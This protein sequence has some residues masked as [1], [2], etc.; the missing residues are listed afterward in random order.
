ML[1][2]PP[3]TLATVGVGRLDGSVWGKSGEIDH[4]KCIFS[5]CYDQDL[6]VDNGGYLGVSWGLS[7]GMTGG[8]YVV[9]ERCL[10]DV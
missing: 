6:A 3:L 4:T 2:G 7:D 10:G 8:F 5:V 1:W 9:S